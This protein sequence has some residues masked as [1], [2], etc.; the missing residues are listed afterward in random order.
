M[1][2]YISGA[3]TASDVTAI[4][5][6]QNKMVSAGSHTALAGSILPSYGNA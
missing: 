4:A 5:A 1:S 2:S 3:S 6:Q